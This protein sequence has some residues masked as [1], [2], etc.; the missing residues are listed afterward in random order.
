M[1]YGLADLVREMT[2]N[3]K[4]DEIVDDPRIQF[5]T[6]SRP[7]LGASILPVMRSEENTIS[8][9]SINMETVIADDGSP[10]AAPQ[11][12][13]FIRGRTMMAT[14][15]HIDLAAQ[16]SARDMKDLSKLL[17][18]PSDRTLAQ[19]FF[20]AFLTRSV[21][22]GL[23]QKQELQRW[24]AIV[25]GVVQVL[26]KDNDTKTVNL[27]PPAENRITIP[28]GTVAA[29]TGIY[30]SADPVEIFANIL[31]DAA[32]KGITFNRAVTTQRNMAALSANA[33]MIA[34]SQSPVGLQIDNA[35]L[36][37]IFTANGLPIPQTYDEYYR[38]QLGTTPYIPRDLGEP[39]ILLATTGRD[40]QLALPDNDPITLTDT[41][42]Y[43]AEG[44]SIGAAAPGP[45]VTARYKDLKPVGIYTEGYVETFPMLLDIEYVYVIF[46]PRPT[47]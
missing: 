16:M 31:A 10:Y 7:L 5:G 9:D 8:E 12:K 25:K 17:V 3:G 32:E 35:N 29:P 46:F 22:G 36:G 38:T 47:P 34:R 11:I 14:L 15:G 13:S 1:P 39:F 30:G 18:K 24:Q 37:N 33:A 21:L 2:D 19:Q 28:S 6:P 43:Q 44:I 20:A 42:G 26:N 27:N 45:V 23:A 4:I 40:R 41:F